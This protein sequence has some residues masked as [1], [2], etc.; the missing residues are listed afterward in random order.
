MMLWLGPNQILHRN[1]TILL[2]HHLLIKVGIHSTGRECSKI[3][4]ERK[5][6]W[7][8]TDMLRLFG[9]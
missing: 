2:N 1:C 9:L 4:L 6:V 8:I 7:H 5:L 3:M